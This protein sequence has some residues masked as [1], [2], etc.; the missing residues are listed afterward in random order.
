[1]GGGGGGGGVGLGVAGW[2]LG[3]YVERL[4]V[5][6]QPQCS[7]SRKS[8]ASPSPA[9]FTHLTLQPRTSAKALPGRLLAT[10]RS[11]SSLPARA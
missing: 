11:A 9:Y 2:P 7:L 3:V 5:W 10:A 8:Q 1:M 6:L 4:Q